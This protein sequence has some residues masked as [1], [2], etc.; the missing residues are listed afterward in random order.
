MLR[1]ETIS[2]T[3]LTLL[4]ELM[5]LPE[6]QSFRLAGGTALSLQYGHRISIDLDIFTDHSFD[7]AEL[8]MV[9]R[10]QYPTFIKD[11][12][13]RMGFFAYINDVKVDLV[14]W[15]IPFIRPAIDWKG[16]RLCTPEEIAAMK[17]E[18][19][20]TRQVKKDYYDIFELLKYFSMAQIVGFYRERYP[21]NNAKSP[22]A[23]LVAAHLADETPEPEMLYNL[24]W[25]T[26]KNHIKSETEKYLED[27]K[28]QKQEADKGV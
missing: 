3:C 18:A 11:F 25:Q 2:P 8:E 15:S 28:Q 5:Q 12:S 27:L 21:Y 1:T 19:L 7:I 23:F 26:V 20:N 22:I 10:Q 4:Q 16:I 17:L 14:N 9:L 13:N 6:L 24:D